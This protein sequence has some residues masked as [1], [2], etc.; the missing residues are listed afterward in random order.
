VRDA[1]RA[2]YSDGCL[3]NAIDA[4]EV[5]RWFEESGRFEIAEEA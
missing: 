5:F 2:A 3:L 1:L 4:A